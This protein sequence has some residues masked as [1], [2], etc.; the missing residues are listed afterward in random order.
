MDPATDIASAPLA[1]REPVPAM[2][3]VAVRPFPE[4]FSAVPVIV[5]FPARMLAAKALVNAP[6]TVT[7]PRFTEPVL[8][9]MVPA[10]TLFA[11]PSTRD[12]VP[13]T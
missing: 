5:R 6:L 7:V 10:A 11:P 12:A 9:V 1:T 8:S 2:D 13:G 3:P 4:R